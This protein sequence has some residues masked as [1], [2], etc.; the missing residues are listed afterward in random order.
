[1]SFECAVV[2]D[3][4]H[5]ADPRPGDAVYLKFLTFCETH[6]AAF[7]DVVLGDVLRSEIAHARYRRSDLFKML[8]EA[9]RDRPATFP[10]P[11]R[12]DMRSE[13][14]VYFLR[15]ELYIKIGYA[16][17]PHKRLKQIR[18]KDG[19]KYPEGIDCSTAALIETEP[20]GLT[21]ERELHAK[22]SHLRH[23]GEWFTETKELTDY[24]KGL[25]A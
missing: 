11:P 24:I 13:A 14:T 9:Q 5:C 12:R 2:H 7:E 16:T 21:R 3:G 18:A 19:T 15:C 23:T 17:A 4:E 10:E 8:E 25:A 6:Q 20:G 22:F 1:M